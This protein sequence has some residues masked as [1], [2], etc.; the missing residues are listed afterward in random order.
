MIWSR[1]ES[2][3]VEDDL[4]DVRLRVVQNL[5]APVVTMSTWGLVGGRPPAPVSNILKTKCK[6]SSLFKITPDLIVSCLMLAQ[7]L[8]GTE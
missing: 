6:S 5:L 2:Q 8:D 7:R 3:S 1:T 4:L